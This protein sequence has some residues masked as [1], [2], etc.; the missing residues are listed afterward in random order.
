MSLSCVSVP[1][2]TRA[3]TGQTNA[4]LLGEETALLIDPAA[5]TDRLDAA[6]TEREV[7][8]IAVT[9][10]HPDHVGGVQAYADR[11]GAT[12]WARSGRIDRF[13]SATGVTP[14]RH[15]REGTEIPVDP[16]VGVRELPGH[17]PD[18]V[19]FVV[20]TG[21]GAVAV[22][23]DVA[24]AEG[25]VVVGREDGDMR[26]YMTSLRRLIVGE[27]A[28]LYPGHGPPITDPGTRLATLLD[29]RLTRERRVEEA[30]QSGCH[31]I[32]EIL[33]AA[34]EKDL[35]GVR[36]L[37]RETVAA[38]LQKLAVEG[39]VRWDGTTATPGTR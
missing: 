33:A 11:T 3:P 39:R 34:Y 19:G 10:T 7:D 1:V 36:D 37:A 12:V 22:I 16:P 4:Y 21:A 30:V 20:A 35:T 18:H 2:S 6:V 32:D 25:S 8:H 23:G 28:T 27:Y 31:T 13:E 24:T 29:H 17:A 26:A 38:H 9:H 15:L 5:V 14:D